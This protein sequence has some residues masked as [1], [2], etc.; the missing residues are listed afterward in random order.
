MFIQDLREQTSQAH[1][2]AEQTEFMKQ[3]FSGSL[4]LESY[5]KYLLALRSVYS[6]MEDRIRLYRDSKI[7]SAIF[8]PRLER[9]KQ[10]SADIKSLTSERI[11]P[12]AVIDIVREYVYLIKQANEVELAAHHYIRYLGDLSGG[13]AIKKILERSYGLSESQTNFYNFDIDPKQYRDSY[14]EALNMIIV[15]DEQKM[16]FANTVSKVYNI[17]TKMLNAIMAS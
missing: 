17:T 14:K 7:I 6:T 4:P 8:D 3:L 1:S 2:E 10:I 5:A 15:T 11:L 13:Q 16:E 12:K 9:F